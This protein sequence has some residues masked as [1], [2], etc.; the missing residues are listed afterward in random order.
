MTTRR[1]LVAGA[2]LAGLTAAISLVEA[3]VDVALVE[4]RDTVGGASRESAGWIWR[5]ND[6]AGYRTYAPGG[7]REVQQAVLTTFDDAVEW[8]A[9]HGVAVLERDPG[10]SFTAG[11][12]IDTDQAFDAL[13]A[14]VPDRQLMTSTV[15]TTVAPAGP[16][17]LC[18]QVQAAD[19][20]RAEQAYDA[21]VL[22]GG[23]YASQIDRIATEAHVGNGV[24]A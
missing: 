2:G 18:C 23:G 19:G 6:M 15:L 5:Y 14:H 9:Q 11:I 16:D 3:G 1:V 20:T 24:A 8:L 13:V 22:A 10:R 12:R 4:R 21:V 17:R 7:S